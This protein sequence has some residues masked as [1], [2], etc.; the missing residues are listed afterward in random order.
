MNGLH[1]HSVWLQCVIQ[2]YIH[3]YLYIYIQIAVTLCE[4]FQKIACNKCSDIQKESHHVNEPSVFQAMGFSTIRK[5]IQH[6]PVLGNLSGSTVY[7]SIVTS[8]IVSVAF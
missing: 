4:Q 2:I 6:R 5:S 7:A 1:T 3:M 8:T